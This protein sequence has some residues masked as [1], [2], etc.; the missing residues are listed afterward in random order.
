[1]PKGGAICS[2]LSYNDRGKRLFSDSREPSSPELVN[3]IRLELALCCSKPNK[4]MPG[5]MKWLEHAIRRGNFFG[6]LILLQRGANRNATLVDGT[7]L[8]DFALENDQDEI[9]VLLLW[10]GVDP[11]HDSFTYHHKVMGSTASGGDAKFGGLTV[12]M[13]LKSAAEAMKHNAE[14]WMWRRGLEVFIN[15]ILGAEAKIGMEDHT[16]MD[17]DLGFKISHLL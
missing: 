6:A 13:R 12:L 7:P 16:L 10:L 8:A 17:A 11:R 3:S 5:G 9:A 4:D 1:V 2:F 15:R 14:D